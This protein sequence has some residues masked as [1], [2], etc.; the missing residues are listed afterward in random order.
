MFGQCNSRLKK[1]PDCLKKKKELFEV[2]TE[3][4][5]RLY[6]NMPQNTYCNVQ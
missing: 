2:V 3:I 6:L 4:F 1:L 5:E